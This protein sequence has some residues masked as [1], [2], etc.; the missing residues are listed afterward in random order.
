MSLLL[1]F[2]SFAVEPNNPN[3]IIPLAVNSGFRIFKKVNISFF[4]LAYAF[5]KFKFFL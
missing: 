5:V 1:V 2:V 4:E 3:E